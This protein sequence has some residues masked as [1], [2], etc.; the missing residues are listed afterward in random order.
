VSED[1]HAQTK[2]KL[3]LSNALG[4]TSAGVAVLVGLTSIYAAL[5]AM[6]MSQ[7]SAQQMLFENQLQACLSL[8]VTT[9]AINKNHGDVDESLL[10][11]EREASAKT[12]ADLK[13]TLK[14]N[15]ETY[16]GLHQEYLK[17]AMLMPDAQLADTVYEALDN[18]LRSNNM[19]WEIYRLGVVTAA[20][21]VEIDRL[22]QAEGDRLS[23]AGDRCTDHIAAIVRGNG[24]LLQD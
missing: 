24:R 9:A 5:E 16:A 11:L 22:W 18:H 8:N 14:Q 3:S 20:Q 10:A 6:Q 19:A 1:S 21:R 15:D 2:R 4:I 7:A 13:S 23:L 12:L 17:I